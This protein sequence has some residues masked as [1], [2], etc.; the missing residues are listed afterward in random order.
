MPHRARY[1]LYYAPS[2]DHPLRRTAVR[3]LGRDAFGGRVPARTL[4]PAWEPLVTD[5]RRYGFHATL[6]PPMRLKP[7][8]HS[9][10]LQAAAGDFARRQAPLDIG[11]LKVARIGHFFALVPEDA[12]A[13]L[14]TLADAVV[15]EFDRF[16]APMG[17]E[18]F[19]RRNGSN[20]DAVEV[21]NLKT[22][23]YPYVFGRFRFHMSLTGPVPEELRAA[24]GGHLAELFADSLRQP[25]VLDALTIFMEEVPEADFV[26]LSRA[27]FGGQA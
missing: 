3:W 5:P 12:P 25:V 18:E 21:E 11:C 23:G 6:K 7:E 20:L 4:P 9:W 14:R 17:A 24:V 15:T 13:A 16:R 26:A 10:D 19:A 8:F 2:I 22:W 1:A 27:E